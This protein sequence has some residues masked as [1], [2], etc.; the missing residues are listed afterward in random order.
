MRYVYPA[1]FTRDDEFIF[2]EFPDL[3]EAV[4]QGND[5]D[6]ALYMAQDVLNTWLAFLE[7]TGKKIPTPSDIKSIELDDGQFAN[8]ILA[9]TDAWRLLNAGKATA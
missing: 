1:I 5:L 6:D 7:D 4:T 2:V 3:E 9:D 8:L